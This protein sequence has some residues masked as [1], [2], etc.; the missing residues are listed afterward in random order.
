V[1]TASSDLPIDVDRLS[2]RLREVLPEAKFAYLFGSAASGR[3]RPGSDVDV[4]VDA[5]RKLTADVIGRASSQL[6]KLVDGARR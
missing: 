6:E 1:S 4:A 5:G 2:A 3:M